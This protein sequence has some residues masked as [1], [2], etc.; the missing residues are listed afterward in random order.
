[1]PTPQALMPLLMGM[2]LVVAW[3][4]L[5]CALGHLTPRLISAPLSAVFVYYLITK[6]GQVEPVWLRHV[7][8]ASDTSLDFGEQYGR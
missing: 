4:V 5:G 7:S 2:G 3:A 8:G 1:M 6:T